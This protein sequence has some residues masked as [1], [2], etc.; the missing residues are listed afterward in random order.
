MLRTSISPQTIS[1]AGIIKMK[2]NFT[3]AQVFELPNSIGLFGFSSKVEQ[4]AMI[5]CVNLQMLLQS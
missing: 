5:F 2:H 3:S 1:C 4:I